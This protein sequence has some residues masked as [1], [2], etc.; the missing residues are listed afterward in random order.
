MALNVRQRLAQLSEEVSKARDL[1]NREAVGFNVN[2]EQCGL[3][4]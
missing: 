3:S 4:L 1:S 2:E